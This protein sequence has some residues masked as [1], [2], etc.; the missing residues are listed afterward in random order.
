ML[1]PGM[2]ATSAGESPV[3][4]GAG[5]PCGGEHHFVWE[6]RRADA[7]GH[8]GGRGGGLFRAQRGRRVAEQLETT[9]MLEPIF[10]AGR[11]WIALTTH[12]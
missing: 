11:V 3:L 5:P 6:T 1:R 8:D 12:G 7:T 2:W 9:L 10:H 4:V